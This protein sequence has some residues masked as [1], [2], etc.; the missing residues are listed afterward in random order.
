MAYPGA[1]DQAR[2]MAARGVTIR[3]LD[4]ERWDEELGRVFDVARESFRGNYLY[5]PLDEASFRAQYGPARAI[6]RP[7]LVSIAEHEG[8][9]VGFCFVVPNVAE[10]QRGE[11]V[12]S[13]IAKTFAVRRGYTGLGGV[14]AQRTHD[15][16][17]AAG[18]TRMIHALIHAGNDRSRALSERTARVIRRYAL[19]ERRLARP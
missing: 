17:R 2:A 8:R 11:R 18:F 3:P 16:A 5:T 1:A 14:L 15:V 4:I 19:F 10:A 7:E 6:V 12:R 9:C 13:A